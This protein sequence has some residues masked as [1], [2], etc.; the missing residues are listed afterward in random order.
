MC[1]I[2][3]IY[4]AGDVALARRM[5]EALVH[6]GPDNG[7]AVGG[8]DFALAARRLSI[9]DLDGGRQ[10]LSNETDDVWVAQNGE[11]YNFAELR[12]ELIASG[13]QFRTRCDTEVLVHLFEDEGDEMLSRLEGMFAIAVWDERRGRGLLARDRLGKKPLYYTQ[14]GDVLYF[15][16]EIKSLLRIPGFERRLT[17]QALHHYL[18]FKQFPHPLSIFE[19][20]FMLP[21]GHRLS[22][23]HGEAPRVERWWNPDFSRPLPASKLQEDVLV[24]ELLSLLR[25]SIERRMVS[26]VP[27]GFFLSGGLDSALVTALAS[28]ISVE[29]IR[30]FTLVYGDDSTTAGKEQ[31]RRFA[32]DVASLFGTKH[33]E[34]QIELG[35][36]ADELPNILQQFDEP[37]SGVFSSYFLS[38][39]IS[40][41]VKVCMSGDGADE[42]FGSYLSHRIAQ[43]IAD[44]VAAQASGAPPPDGLLPF[45]G[46]DGFLE[47]LAEAEDWRWRA[48]LLV[49]DEE[50]KFALYSRSVAAKLAGVSTIE[51][52]RRD[53]EGLT[54]VDPL[55]RMLEAELKHIFTDQVLCYADRLSMAHSLEVRSPFLDSDLVNFVTRLPAEWKIRDGTTKYLLKRAALRYLPEEMVYRPKEGFL[56]P[57]TQW[58]VGGLEDYV[59]SMLG[60]DQLGRHGL[61]D[62]AAV[63]SL[64]DRLYGGDSHYTVVNRVLSLVVFQQWYQLYMEPSP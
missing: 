28:E 14:L 53:F 17:L 23:T 56:M 22:Y 42:L 41:H 13:H 61:F 36:L 40:R 9:I 43:P 49:F 27:V 46:R 63:N 44:F 64:L 32:L 3:G 21:P 11:I 26:D 1:G 5:A 34:Q 8:R 2:A 25:R 10:P 39:L 51:W 31:D 62:Q 29:P 33:L 37:F 55:N 24:D 15:A 60:P 6:R 7:H 48:K 4:G 19:G 16:S 57:V 18:S 59:R 35:S 54:A 58:L 30:T 12:Q 52:M 20:V 45:E 47:S 38:R 50:E